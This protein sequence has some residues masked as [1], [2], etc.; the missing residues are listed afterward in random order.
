MLIQILLVACGNLARHLR[1]AGGFIHFG[2]GLG[3]VDH[4]IADVFQQLV[5]AVAG[6]GD[7]EELRRFVN[8][9]GIALSFTE[10]LVGQNIGDKGDIGFYTAHAGFAQGAQGFVAG[11]GEGIVA[12]GNFHQQGVVIRRDFRAGIAVSAVQTDAEAAGGT[13]GG[14]FSGVRGE[15]VGRV[16]G[17]HAALDG[18]APGLDVLLAGDADFGVTQRLARGDQQLGAHQIHARNHFGDGV[19]HL[20]A[21]VHF[22]EV[23]VPLAVHQEFHCAG[24]DKAH[25]LGDLHCVGAQGVA[26]LLIHRKGGGELHYLLETALQGAVAL[27]EMDDVAVSVGQNL[28]LDVFGLLKKFF[29]EDTV[30]PEGFGGLAFHQVEGGDHFLLA[31]A[32]AHA[33]AAAAGCRLEHNG[34]AVFP[35]LFQGFLAA[36]ERL[37]AAGDDGYPAADGRF[38]GG[39]LVAHLGKHMGRR[40]D[41]HDAVFFAGLGKSGVFGQKSVTG[42]DSVHITA[43]GQVDNGGNVQ[44]GTKRPEG[45]GHL[46]GFVRL[47]AEEAVG[48]LFGIHGHRADIEVRAGAEH[49]D[50]NFAA[51]GHQNL[52]D[53]VFGHIIFSFIIK[54]PPRPFPRRGR[55]SGPRAETGAAAPCKVS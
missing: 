49:A 16:L 36:F 23:V 30:V 26:H 39:K 48:I 11:A 18:V 42:M 31:V 13:V 27:V 14:D 19:F 34:E 7:I 38:F 53:R 47:S 52:L 44:I 32:A 51:V 8:E 4:D 40:A 35:G 33:A 5:A 17:G 55:R 2:A 10:G 9:F 28:H 12:A 25:R 6:L 22:D 21:G 1:H 41:K 45:V 50:G 37:G 24:V 15:I 20:D 54:S 46:I 3:I 43:F 29:D